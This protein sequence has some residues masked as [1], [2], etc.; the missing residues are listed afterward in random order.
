MRDLAWVVAG[1]LVERGRI[2]ERSTPASNLTGLRGERT[3]MSLARRRCE[4]PD[5]TLEWIIAE[6][7]LVTFSPTTRCL[8]IEREREQR[9][10]DEIR[11]GIVRQR[12]SKGHKAVE[13]VSGCVAWSPI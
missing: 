6:E 5:S 11:P 1:R 4:N 13:N 12:D 3:T 7:E 10:G 8:F 2:V 9:G